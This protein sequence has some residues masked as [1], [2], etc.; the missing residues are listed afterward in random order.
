MVKMIL[1]RK[2]VD[3]IVGYWIETEHIQRTIGSLV[4]YTDQ[5]G[6]IYEFS[7]WL[8]NNVGKNGNSVMTVRDYLE[9]T[10]DAAFNVVKEAET[11]L[12]VVL[13][14]AMENKDEMFA[15]YDDVNLV[16]KI[17]ALMDYLY[18]S[19][20]EIYAYVKKQQIENFYK[21]L[22]QGIEKIIEE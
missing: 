22:H 5:V 19:F 4:E 10:D 12:K 2:T 16:D 6:E 14:A 17:D 1:K 18:E 7:D 8:K 15:R 3:E 9:K 20:D 13:M 21:V 11:K